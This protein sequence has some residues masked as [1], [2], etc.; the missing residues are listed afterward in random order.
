MRL[1]PV[2]TRVCFFADDILEAP[3]PAVAAMIA[4]A[5]AVDSTRA[6]VDTVFAVAPTRA[7][8]VVA[9]RTR[10]RVDTVFAAAPTRA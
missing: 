8:A 5:A 6:R 4:R 9:G 1:P 3:V 7:R 2:F 10:A